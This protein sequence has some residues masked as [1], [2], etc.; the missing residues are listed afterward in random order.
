MSR[1]LLLQE[2]NAFAALRIGR[3]KI[4]S[5]PRLKGLQGNGTMIGDLVVFDLEADPS[6]SD[7][8]DIKRHSLRFALASGAPTADKKGSDRGQEA[9]AVEATNHHK[10]GRRR[11]KVLPKG[12]GQRS[13]VDDKLDVAFVGALSMNTGYDLQLTAHE[14]RSV[15]LYIKEAVW[16]DIRATLQSDGS[17]RK[18]N[19]NSL[20]LPCA[21]PWVAGAMCVKCKCL[22]SPPTEAAAIARPPGRPC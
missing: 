11:V 13:D 7:R 15:A 14:F 22:P 9:A 10:E 20:G 21:L 3:Y 1:A 5:M 18:D 4:A 17:K 12:G 2:N 19:Q 6:E 8:V 16:A